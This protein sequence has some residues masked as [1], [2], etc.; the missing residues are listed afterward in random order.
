MKKSILALGLAGLSFAGYLSGVKLFTK[1]CALG[2]TCPIFIGLPAC[3]YGF[4][5]YLLITVF[6]V[7]L[8]TGKWGERKSLTSIT[9]VSFLGILFA[10]YFTL[11]E[12]PLLFANGFSAYFFGL[13]T[14]AL[15]LIFY[16]AIFILS[17]ISFKR[18]GK[19]SASVV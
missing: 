6:A 10:G 3:Y 17:L 14:R 5:M 13:P 16:I 15:G 2:E 1:T 11:G 4:A 7:L 8:V 19:P 12:M 18:T 9:I